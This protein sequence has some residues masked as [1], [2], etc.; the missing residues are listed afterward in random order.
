[1]KQYEE[2]RIGKRKSI[3]ECTLP[4][5]KITSE[6]DSWLKTVGRLRCTKKVCKKGLYKFKTFV[7]ADQWMETMI[8]HNSQE[9]LR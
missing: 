8:A 7:E 5:S 1:M 4:S 2:K 9:S 6:A 3:E